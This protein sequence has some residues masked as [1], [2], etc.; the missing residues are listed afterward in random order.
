MKNLLLTRFRQNP[1]LMSIDKDNNQYEIRM[2]RYI[3]LIESSL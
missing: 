2:F 3:H 1:T